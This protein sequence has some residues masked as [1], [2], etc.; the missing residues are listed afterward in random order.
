MKRKKNQN[1]FNMVASVFLGDV[2]VIWCTSKVM[3][4]IKQLWLCVG[5]IDLL[6]S[7]LFIIWIT[8]TFLQSFHTTHALFATLDTCTGTMWFGHHKEYMW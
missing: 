2:G 8:Y 4:P 7:L 3:V 1:A 5:V 6:M